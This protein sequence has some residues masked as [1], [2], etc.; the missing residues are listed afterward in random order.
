MNKH[1]APNAAVEEGGERSCA[2]LKLPGAF[3]KEGEK[4]GRQGKNIM[5]LIMGKG[6]KA[7]PRSSTALG[8]RVY[9]ENVSGGGRA[10][11]ESSRSLLWGENKHRISSFPIE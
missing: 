9:W 8:S 6:E 2:D 4:G 1:L 11:G 3:S 7:N 5:I 10:S